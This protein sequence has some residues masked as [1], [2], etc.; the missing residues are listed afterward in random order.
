MD[1]NAS[2]EILSESMDRVK[3]VVLPVLETYRRLVVG[4]TQ[5]P[6][7]VSSLVANKLT[8]ILNF[9]YFEGNVE[10]KV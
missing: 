1:A 9:I 7:Y 5:T 6:Y 3:A 4:N 10:T 8:I 2:V